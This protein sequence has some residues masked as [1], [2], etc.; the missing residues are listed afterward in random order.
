METVSSNAVVARAL[1]Q[2]FKCFH[3]GDVSLFSYAEDF[4]RL[5][6]IEQFITILQSSTT[7]VV[8]WE[9][10]RRPAT[11][12]G[13][14]IS[15]W[16][17]AAD[18]IVT[19]AINAEKSPAKE[20]GSGLCI[21]ELDVLQDGASRKNRILRDLLHTE[22]SPLPWI[23]MVGPLE[24]LRLASILA[25]PPAAHLTSNASA[26]LR[27]FWAAE[28]TSPVSEVDRHSVTNLV[29]PRVL[30][31]SM[32]TDESRRD[33]E[34]PSVSQLDRMM[35]S[36][37][38][39]PAKPETVPAPWVTRELWTDGGVV[40]R[41]VLVD[42]MAKSGWADF[43]RSAADVRLQ[44][45][46]IVVQL[47][48]RPNADGSCIL[49]QRDDLLAPDQIVFLDL[50]LFANDWGSERSFLKF[51]ATEAKRLTQDLKSYAWPT[52]T[53]DEIAAAERAANHVTRIEN[54]DYHVALTFLPRLLALEDPLLPIV[55]FSSTGRREILDRLRPYG[56]VITDFDKPRF[57]GQLGPTLLLDCRQRFQRALEKAVNVARGRR[58]CR[59]VAKLAPACVPLKI[60][61]HS[62]E[63][64]VSVYIDE[65]APKDQ[66]VPFS[67]GGFALIAPSAGQ[68]TA[69][70]AELQSRGLIWGLAE[71]CLPRTLNDNLPSK[72][73][74]KYAADYAAHLEQLEALFQE[75][76][77]EIAA[78]ALVQTVP[79]SATVK[80][81]G[82]PALLDEREID[83]LYRTML[84]EVLEAVLFDLIPEWADP[85]RITVDV[86]TR[87]GI[88]SDRA[89][90]DGLRDCFGVVL[91]DLTG[92][93]PPRYRY[94]SL[95]HADVY[96]LVAKLLFDRPRTGWSKPIKAARGVTLTDFNKM[97]E[98]RTS[99]NRRDQDRYKRLVTDTVHPR[100]NAI[101]YLADW[102]AR[103]G[104]LNKRPA[105][106]ERWFRS[107]FLQKR[108]AAFS[109]WLRAGRAA[110]HGE[111]LD[112]VAEIA[113]S[114][115]TAEAF[116][117]SSFAR[118]TRGKLVQWTDNIT[119]A[120]LLALCD[121][122]ASFRSRGKAEAAK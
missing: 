38:L 9:E 62:R 39:I 99:T 22:R 70:N 116:S 66:P 56:N 105:T 30:A 95:D 18:W 61:V 65:A 112:A 49:I 25:K 119:G 82:V 106:A 41:F 52:F 85:G 76:N 90:M 58:L 86:A 12:L 75:L 115:A 79:L 6:R 47:G 88:A 78:F 100:P 83:N 4:D 114:G 32:S 122:L 20:C 45:L 81:A 33:A 51:L 71:H 57:F 109:S 19:L 7:P 77:I 103:F 113:R 96:P 16:T 74:G 102:I 91:Q 26:V 60:G 46:A 28:L 104:Y 50:R 5:W 43:L 37:D 108:N 42:D 110:D 92:D 54:A 2:A 36:L 31:L 73:L 48:T 40:R 68:I 67:V 17:T 69:L 98:L 80:T 27:P 72:Y 64:V 97:N 15:A 111:Y 34:T 120:E 3:C 121:R 55:L 101:H 24:L 11:I 117:D 13:M 44:E 107:G 89:E 10:I 118:W 29:A 23:T 94:Y 21:L 35:E 63:A 1:E 59:A 93:V 84:A 8:V 87:L 53:H 14:D